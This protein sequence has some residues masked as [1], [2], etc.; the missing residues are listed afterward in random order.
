VEVRGSD[1]WVVANR[2]R[3]CRS[4]GTLTGLVLCNVVMWW[5]WP[6]AHG[7]IVSPLGIVLWGVPLACDMAYPFLLWR[8]RRT[9]VVLPSGRVVRG[10]WK[11]GVLEVNDGKKRQ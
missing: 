5:Y 4:M 7:F 8:V 1:G 10:E 9:E 3:L 2:S 6:E 11:G